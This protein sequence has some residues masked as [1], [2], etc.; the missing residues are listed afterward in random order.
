M[1]KHLIEVAI[2]DGYSCDD[3]PFDY[4]TIECRNPEC[5]EGEWD[6]SEREEGKAWVGGRRKW[7]VK[8][9]G[10]SEESTR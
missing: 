6:K 7:C 1:S 9:Y 10:V 2:P 3:C 5:P 8:K 4:D